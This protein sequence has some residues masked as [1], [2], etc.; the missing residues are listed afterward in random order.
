MNCN[1]Q[2]AK[3]RGRADFSKYEAVAGIQITIQKSPKKFK[4]KDDLLQSLVICKISIG[5]LVFVIGKVAQV[6]EVGLKQT[7][8][9]QDCY[10]SN[11]CSVLLW[12]KRVNA[13]AK[14]IFHTD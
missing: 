4:T 3:K 1:I 12:Q 11:I 6:E 8:V 9:K 13:L 2:K 5:S 7:L 14:G 10:L